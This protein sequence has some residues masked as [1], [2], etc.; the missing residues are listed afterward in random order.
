MA[1]DLPLLTL[2]RVVRGRSP[3]TSGPV[4]SL[5]NVVGEGGWETRTD[6]AASRGVGRGRIDAHRRSAGIMATANTK[7][8]AG[9]SRYDDLKAMLETRR[10]ELARE[11]RGKIRDART[12]SILERDVLDQGESSEV[13]I[14]DAIGFALIQMKAETLDKID[15][16]LQRLDEGT[17]GDCVD[18]GAEIAGPRLRALPFAVRCRDCEGARETVERR[19][20]VMAERRGSSALFA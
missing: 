9:S 15:A 8:V 16:A 5:S 4:W 1:P 19:E 20:R 6:E 17:Y 10:R 14:Q 2:G 12:D 18:C 3:R 13:D 11:V 7:S